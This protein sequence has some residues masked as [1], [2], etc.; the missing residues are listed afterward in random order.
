MNDPA[1]VFVG[2]TGSGKTCLLSAIYDNMRRGYNGF[3][4]SAND[5]TAAGMD[6]VI[7]K[8]E[9]SKNSLDRF[10]TPTDD[11]SEYQFELNYQNH[12]VYDFSVIDYPGG[13]LTSLTSTQDTLNEHIRN[14]P[15]IFVCVSVELFYTPNQM[16][17][18]RSIG[19][20][21]SDQK[22]I[23]RI[24]S[25][26]KA[27]RKQLEA[28]IKNTTAKT[29]N[30]CFVITKYDLICSHFSELRIKKIFQS[31]F[32]T[33]FNLIRAVRKDV[34]ISIIKV[35]LGEKISSNNYTG[36]YQPYNVH[37]PILFGVFFSLIENSL[38]SSVI[39]NKVKRERAKMEYELTMKHQE[40]SAAKQLL[41]KATF[42][43]KG[44][45]KKACRLKEAELNNL[46]EKYNS[47]SDSNDR[48]AFDIEKMERD[49]ESIFRE[50]DN[51]DQMLFKNG[52]QV[53]WNVLHD[54]YIE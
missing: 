33:V 27:I 48:M 54:Y 50:L 41:E 5:R 34:F 37:L 38:S 10:P 16:G 46:I 11:Y 23:E 8:L 36:R 43:E 6:R 21:D 28:Y 2:N 22:V 42:W 4:I 44:R 52:K 40:L 19:F 29:T 51:S 7:E 13:N 1:Y 35:S 53:K 14:C 3:S 30:I 25:K 32:D 39:I 18:I 12:K 47:L 17:I 49:L 9:N 24:G 45:I 31:A 15:T 26:T 20:T